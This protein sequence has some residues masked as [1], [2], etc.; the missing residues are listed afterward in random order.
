MFHVTI[1]HQPSAVYSEGILKLTARA[2]LLVVL[3]ST[4]VSCL[5][6]PF[7]EI[8]RLG[9]RSDMGADIIWFETCK[10]SV[11]DAFYFF[12]V[13]SGFE[14]AH[15]IIR[16]L[17]GAI[18][19]ST[20]VFLILE[21]SENKDMQL[22]FISR[23]HYGC[24]EYPSSSRAR[25]LQ[26]GMRQLSSTSQSPLY[27]R[28][29]SLAADDHLYRPNSTSSPCPG[30]KPTGISLMEWAKSQRSMEQ[31]HLPVQLGRLSLDSSASSQGS[32]SGVVVDGPDA[33]H[34]PH[35]PPC[36]SLQSPRRKLSQ[37]SSHS[38]QGSGSGVSVSGSGVSV[39]GSGSGV[40]V[41]VYSDDCPDLNQT[42]S[43]FPRERGAAPA[44]APR[45]LH[46]LS[47]SHHRFNSL[48][49]PPKS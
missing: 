19:R 35:L 26:V 37:Q 40:S 47:S 39:F 4:G 45:P 49:R 17:K 24:E 1:P 15:Q 23:S 36:H 6:F 38:S 20:G 5:E 48:E 28:F 42:W 10:K 25:I 32:D 13:A 2:H 18:E 30:P 43:H 44:I 21:D 29:G 33:R 46:S 9:C 11:P 41:S 16:D 12:S 7:D 31:G 8:R 14:V 22:S 34:L 27:N 3:P